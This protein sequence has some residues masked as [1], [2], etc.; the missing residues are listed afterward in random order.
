MSLRRRRVKVG[1]MYIKKLKTPP[2][3]EEQDKKLYAKIQEDHVIKESS[4]VTVVTDD[5][6]RPAIVGEG[7]LL[8]EK[9]DKANIDLSGKELKI[10]TD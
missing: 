8:A 9:L 1:D 10:P 7:Q 5:D 3:I 6:S 4:G 2:M